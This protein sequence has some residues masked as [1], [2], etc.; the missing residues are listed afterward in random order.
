MSETGEIELPTNIL[1]LAKILD[2]MIEN[3]EGRRMCFNLIIFDDEQ[4]SVMQSISNTER[5]E[6]VDA[7][8]SLL[9]GMNESTTDIPKSKLN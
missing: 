9:Y 6:V 1:D 3:I 7:L 8:K 4:D 2:A 5:N